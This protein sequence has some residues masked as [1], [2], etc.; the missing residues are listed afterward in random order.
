M[1]GWSTTLGTFVPDSYLPPDGVAPN[2]A[3]D[4]SILCGNFYGLTRTDFRVHGRQHSAAW[5][6]ALTIGFWKNWAS[7]SKSE[8]AKPCWTRR[9]P[10]RS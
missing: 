2:P 3:V 5:R 8:A 1:P 10:R 6:R 7:C 9:S 4:N